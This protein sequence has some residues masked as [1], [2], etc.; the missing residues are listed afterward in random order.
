MLEQKCILVVDDDIF[1]HEFLGYLL[2]HESYK[3]IRAYT[4]DEAIE[5]VASCNPDLIILDLALPGLPGEDVLSTIRKDS[6]AQH[7]PV[8][9]ISSH[10]D[11][12][13]I[14]RLLE[15]GA[16]DFL[17]KPVPPKVM[18]AKIQSLLRRQYLPK[19]EDIISVNGLVVNKSRHEI[20]ID[21]KLVEATKNEFSIICLLLDNQSEVITRDQILSNIRGKKNRA[22]RRSVDVHINSIRKKLKP[23][24]ENIM[25]IRGAGYSFLNQEN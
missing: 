8:L 13:G 18:L 11:P 22:S 24:G 10:A 21:G 25:A 2:R 17:S 7:A 16:D 3:T 9:V 14:V 12:E 6:C 15:M 5:K 19:S 4:G 23:Y 20:R 1:Y